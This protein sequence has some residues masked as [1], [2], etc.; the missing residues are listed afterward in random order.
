MTDPD[1]IDF[2]QVDDRAR[3]VH[4]IPYTLQYRGIWHHA[5]ACSD[6]NR[7]VVKEDVLRLR[8]RVV[9]ENDLGKDLLDR[10]RD[11]GV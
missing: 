1:K 8:R 5:F 11:V 4:A 6:E 10:A 3:V 2:V 9:A 7:N